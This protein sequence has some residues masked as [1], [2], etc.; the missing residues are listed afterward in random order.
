ML[1]LALLMTFG[2][3]MI[4]LMFRSLERSHAALRQS[5]AIFRGMVEALPDVV[6]RFDREGRH[7]FASENVRDAV[8]IEASSFLGKTHRELGFP[9]TLCQFFADALRVAFDTGKPYET[10][11]A[12]DG[13]RGEAVHNWR[14]MPEFDDGVV[15][16]VLSLSRDVTAERQ[17]VA[18][19]RRMAAAMEN[20]MDGIAILNREERYVYLNAAH[21][22]VYGYDHPGEL[23]GLSWTIL[24][25]DTELA[26]FQDTIMPSFQ[27]EG[28]WRGEAMGKKKDGSLF[29]QEVSLTGLADGGLVCMV[30]DISD[31]KTSEEALKQSESRFRLFAE[32]A[33]V[34][35]VVSDVKENTL[36]VS[37]KFVEMFGYAAE[38]M[39]TVEAWW[40]L[41]YPDAEL[42]ERVRDEWKS[43]LDNARRTGTDIPAF[44]FP[45][46]CKDGTVRYIEF[47]TAVTGELNFVVFSDVSDRK[48]AEETL[49]EREQRFQKMLRLVPDM[50]SIHDPEMNILYS[51]WRGFAEVP[52]EKRRQNSKCYFA[53]RGLNDVCPDCLAKTVLE[54]RAPLAREVELEGGTWIDLRVIP[55]LDDNGR[56]EMFMEWVRDISAEK[57]ASEEKA[58]LEE[59][60]RQ[61]QK[62]ESVGRLAGGVAHDF[63]NMLNVILGHAEMALEHA[64]PG[65]P[66]FADLVEIQKA[67]KRS[68][69]LTRQL[70]AFARKQTA[71]P[72]TLDLNETMEG[73]LK[74]L[75]RLIGEDIELAWLPGSRL[76]TIKM[77]PSQL[78]QILANLCV[79]ARDALGGCGKIAIETANVFLDEAYCDLHPGFS[80]GDY[81]LLSVSD[82]G[83]GMDKETLSHLFE[84]FFTTKGVGEGTG[85]GLATV[86]GIVKQ[87]SGYINVYSELGYGTSIKIYLPGHQGIPIPVIQEAKSKPALRGSET[88]LLVED[89]PTILKMTAAML[90]RQGYTVLTA[91]TP[92]EAVSIVEQY[93]GHI[94]LLVTDVIMPGMNGRELACSLL[95]QRPELKQLF[96][97]GYTADIIAQRGVL[98]EGMHFIQKPFSLR[99]LSSKVREALE[100]DQEG[101]QKA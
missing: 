64:E 15:R 18:E 40:P 72:K 31:R 97:S 101:I 86:Y 91:S 32:L 33:P 49:H 51:N 19:L 58:R 34:G 88:I 45:V 84:P 53:Y 73:M 77:D 3:I 78:D 92:N 6:M 69:D 56:V 90:K 2:M 54:T 7:L 59:Q 20:S 80:P 87:N 13:L 61:A 67:G 44:E 36:Y 98:E 17:N 37:Q 46:A 76:H 71:A 5:E 89:E 75:R 48:R 81:V 66:M 1:V 79:N 4:N 50:I 65:H 27:Q 30:R 28:C 93:Q 10:E 60:Y 82:T 12:F 99:E 55:L 29:P 74:M 35:I 52:L 100:V 85:L 63:N 11:F 8:G 39:P 83:C 68:A 95:S 47:R 41:A 14:L 21:A 25:D 70:L 24:Y 16:S 26:R 96:M 38:D 62:M 57:R 42:R 94:Q 22:A 23:L 9:E 43:I